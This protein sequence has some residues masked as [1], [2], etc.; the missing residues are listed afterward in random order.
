VKS[1]GSHLRI[2]GLNGY[3][4]ALGPETLQI[5]NDVL[6]IHNFTIICPEPVKTKRVMELIKV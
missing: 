5:V 1:A 4:T 6:K 3:A 2:Y